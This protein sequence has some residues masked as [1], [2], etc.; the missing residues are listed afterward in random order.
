MSNE[1]LK[2]NAVSIAYQRAMTARTPCERVFA[3]D[4]DH[5]PFLG[6]PEALADVLEEVARIEG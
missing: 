6:M 3:L 4:G 2:D 5:S 1:G